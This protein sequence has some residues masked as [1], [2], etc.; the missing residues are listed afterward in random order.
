[1][2]AKKIPPFPALLVESGPSCC[3]VF[4]ECCPPGNSYQLHRDLSAL[5]PYLG[6]AAQ[7]YS[8]RLIATSVC[9]QG[10]LIQTRQVLAQHTRAYLFCRLYR[11]SHTGGMIGAS[12]FYINCILGIISKK[13]ISI[14]TALIQFIL[15]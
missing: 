12:H 5:S 6:R 4:L 3:L 15:T 9:L 7:G 13:N 8:Y 11:W 10:E 2:F 1:M 14:N